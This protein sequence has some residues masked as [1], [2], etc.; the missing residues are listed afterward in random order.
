MLQ[1]VLITTKRQKNNV[2]KIEDRAIVGKEIK[3]IID[4]LGKNNKSAFDVSKYIPTPEPAK[5]ENGPGVKTDIPMPS[6][7]SEQ[8]INNNKPPTQRWEPDKEIISRVQHWTGDEVFAKRKK[9]ENSTIVVSFLLSI[10]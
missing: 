3:G 4:K 8:A 10:R 6:V 9:M 7:R 2:F 1:K 5:I